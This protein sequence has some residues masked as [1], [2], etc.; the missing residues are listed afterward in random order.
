MAKPE[1]SYSCG[2]ET[3]P[4]SCVGERHKMSAPLLPFPILVYLRGE[5]SLLNGCLQV[6]FHDAVMMKFW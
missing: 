1:L 3:L 6:L 2:H 4:R 5:T